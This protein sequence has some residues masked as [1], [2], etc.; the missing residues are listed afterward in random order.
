MKKLI[1]VLVSFLFCIGISTAAMAD[2]FQNGSFEEGPASVD[3]FITL[4]DG[5]TSI[6]GWTVTA[7]SIDL[8]GDYWIA[9]DGERSIDLNGNGPGAISQEFD[10]EPGLIYH[11][12]FD[13]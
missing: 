5:D 2:P 3:S 11:V 6:T 9:S 1:V 7:G 12:L 4:F 13:K 10:T 8:I